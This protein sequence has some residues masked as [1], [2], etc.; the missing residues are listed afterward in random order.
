M[1]CFIGAML[2][3]LCF[4]SYADNIEEIQSLG[5]S[6]TEAVKSKSYV[7]LKSFSN[8][9]EI[10][11]FLSKNKC[12]G[13]KY[14]A[15][16]LADKNKFYLVASKGKGVVIGRHFVGNINDNTVDIDSLSSSTKGCINLGPTQKDSAAK[17]VTHLKPEPS[18]FHV[19]QSNLANIA[20]FVSTKGGLYSVSEGNVKKIKD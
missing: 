14:R 17:F 7:K 9:K 4:Y 6:L 8:T 20:L 5:N 13:Y 1:K 15:Y 10:K 18:E 19:L 11:K 12:P 2:L 3:S 16:V